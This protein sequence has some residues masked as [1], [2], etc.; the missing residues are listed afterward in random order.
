[1]AGWKNIMNALDAGVDHLG[2]CCTWWIVRMDGWMDCMG[3][4]LS[5]GFV[6][7]DVVGGGRYPHA[8]WPPLHPTTISSVAAAQSLLSSVSR[9]PTS[10]PMRTRPKPWIPEMPPT[11]IVFFFRI[12][13]SPDSSASFP[14]IPVLSLLRFLRCAPT[15]SPSSSAH[16]NR[17]RGYWNYYKP[18]RSNSVIRIGRIFPPSFLRLNRFFWGSGADFYENF[19]CSW[20]CR[21]Y[22]IKN[23]FFF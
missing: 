9:H 5:R 23:S 18:K 7:G 11:E 3:I 17:R 20:L 13:P 14:G 2:R 6:R 19:S 21:V 22:A 1:M 4:G 12:C 16:P 15:A 10:K 8:L